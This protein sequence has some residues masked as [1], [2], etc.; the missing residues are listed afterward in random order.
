MV[1]P[2]AATGWSAVCDCGISWSCSLVS[3]DE[4]HI[5]ISNSLVLLWLFLL[6]T[7]VG[8]WSMIVVF[9]GRAHL[10]LSMGPKL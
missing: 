1:F 7:K 8:L 9:P 6:M 3:L 4:A 5:L 10:V 2:L